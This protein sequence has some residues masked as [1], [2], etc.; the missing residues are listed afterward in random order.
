MANDGTWND[1]AFDATIRHRLELLRYEAG[2]AEELVRVYDRALGDVRRE[3][4]RLAARIALGKSTDQLGLDR[5]KLVAADLDNKIKELRPI[6]VKSLEERLVEAA[7]REAAVQAGTFR[8]LT[9]SFVT[10]PESAVALM[11]RQPL[12]GGV[13]TDR[14]ATDLW[15]ARNALQTEMAVMVAQGASIPRI[16]EAIKATGKITETYRGRFVAIARTEVQRV[17]NAV[18]MESYRLNADSLSGVQY[19]ATLDSRTCLVCAPDHN[20][21]YPLGPDG[22]PIGAPIVPRHPRCRCAYAPVS[23][24]W[25]DILGVDLGLN[26]S[27]VTTEPAQD[28]TFD[29]WLKRQPEATQLEILGPARRELWLKGTPLGTFSD[30]RSVLPLG[31][32]RAQTVS[33]ALAR[34]VIPWRDLTTEEIRT[35]SKGADPKIAKLAKKALWKRER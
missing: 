34:D 13:W 29:G 25:A 7:A 31:S 21:V 8:A 33:A 24:S 10:V 1:R 16:A 6:M 19:L 32:L 26:E 17:S 4:A 11:L 9:A 12:G 20:K 3:V 18:A 14:I 15:E 22:R 2:A 23:K 5:L 27:E 35:A 30:G 28:T